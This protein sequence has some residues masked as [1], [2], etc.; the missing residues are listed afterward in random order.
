MVYS[1]VPCV[2]CLAHRAVLNAERRRA[3]E[4]NSVI[5]IFL[6]CNWVAWRVIPRPLFMIVSPAQ[7]VGEVVSD[8]GTASEVVSMAVVM[9][10]AGRGRPWSTIL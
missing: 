9:K 2:F 4:G 1:A 5:T 8:G 6:V 10:M 7:V 3:E